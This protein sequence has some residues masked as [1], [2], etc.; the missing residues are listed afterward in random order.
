MK[1]YNVIGYSIIAVYMLVCVYF[2]PAHLGPWK[3]ALIAAAY[4][5][6][7]WFLAGLY[8]ADVLH[9]GIAHR[10]LDYKP[11]FMKAVTITNN[12]LGIYVDPIA[13]VNRHRLHHT[14]ADHAGDPNK[15]SEDGFWRTMYLCMLPYKCNENVAHDKI[16][17][18]RTFR[19]T[20]SPFFA[21][22][23]QLI[24][25]CLL[26]KLVGDLKFTLAM[27]LVMRVFALW[28]NMI[29]NYWTHTRDFGYRRYDDDDN[30]MNI[31]EWLPVT[32]TFSACLQNNH[33]HYPGLLRLSHDKSEYDFGFIT[34][35]FMKSLG[36]VKATA[37]GESIPKD[38]P[39]EALNF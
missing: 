22:P 15:L 26:W 31:G 16:L 7:C 4:F 23:A 8:L 21:I 17:K 29:Q 33:H 5:L 12:F 39:L 6:F 14:H 30:A 32:A 3:A 37:R 13:W 1:I 24:S 19:V 18:S 9:L 36:L 20:A 25:F 28:V 35:K 2:A 34:V 38:V 27:W 11:W 10:S